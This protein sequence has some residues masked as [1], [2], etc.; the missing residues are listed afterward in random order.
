[1]TFDIHLL[2]ITPLALVI[3]FLWFAMWSILFAPWKEKRD[4]V[5]LWATPVRSL[6][7]WWRDVWGSPPPPLS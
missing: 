3:V 5:Q 7:A 6:S 1:M 2:W 4:E